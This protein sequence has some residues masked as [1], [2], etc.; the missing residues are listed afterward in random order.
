MWKRK[1]HDRR[2]D[3]P[4]P[5]LCDLCARTFP[6][7][8]A[9][10][11]YVAD[12]SAVHPAD[13]LHDGLRRVTA[14]CEAHLE[15]VRAVYRRRPFVQEELWAGKIGRVLGSGPP[16]AT[17]DL[18]CRTGLDEPDIRRAIAWHNERHRHLGA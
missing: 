17:T 13:P 2:S 12:S 7:G 16:V 3:A 5:E 18:A 4:A 11:G 6:P 8:E 10:R 1:K 14:C 9:V 15:E